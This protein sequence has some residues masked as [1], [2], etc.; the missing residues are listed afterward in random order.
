M[1]SEMGERVAIV[2]GAG[3]ELGRATA[4][5]LADQGLTVV[6][7]DRSETG[8]EGLPD[9]IVRQLADATDPEAA[10]PM[11]ERIVDQVGPPH[12]LVNTS[13]DFKPGTPWRPRRTGCT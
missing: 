9:G 11:V 5:K 13:V 1:S 8:L 7:V 6:A 2:V 3:G 12:V 4:V 10:A